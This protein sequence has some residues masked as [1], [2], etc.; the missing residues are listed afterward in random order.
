M[1]HYLFLLVAVVME[2][3]G[4]TALQ[5]SNQFTRLWP[6]LL[7]IVAYAGSFYFLGMTLKFMPV[8]IVYALWSGLGIVLIAIIGFIGFGQRLDAAAIAGLIMIIAGIIVIQVF[9][10]TTSH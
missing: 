8:G 6:T 10:N 4:T 9:S 2:T 3:V 5:A 1:M 7:A